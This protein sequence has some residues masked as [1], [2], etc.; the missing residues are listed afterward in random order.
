MTKLASYE[1]GEGRE[2]A[3]TNKY[4]RGD[5]MAFQIL[6]AFICGTISYFLLLALYVLYGFEDFMQDI[7]KMDILVYAKNILVWYGVFI[8]S[9]LVLTYIIYSLKFRKARKNQKVF[10]MNLKKLSAMYQGKNQ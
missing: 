4:F 3:A 1:S 2:Y 10:Q 7:Y 9:Y 5:Y 8:V 6:W